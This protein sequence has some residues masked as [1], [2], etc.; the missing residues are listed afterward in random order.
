MGLELRRPAQMLVEVFSWDLLT[1]QKY[2]IIL[3]VFFKL[4]LGDMVKNQEEY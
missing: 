1:V 4:G 3:A 2:K